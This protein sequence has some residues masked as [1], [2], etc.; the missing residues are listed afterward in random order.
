M[1]D[2]SN[3][4]VVPNFMGIKCSL[5]SVHSTSVSMLYQIHLVFP[6]CC[7][8]P[9]LGFLSWLLIS[10]LHPVHL[11]CYQLSTT[12]THP[13]SHPLFQRPGLCCALIQ[14]ENRQNNIRVTTS[15]NKTTTV[16]S[17]NW[18]DPVPKYRCDECRCEQTLSHIVVQSL[19]KS[20]WDYVAKAQ[21]RTIREM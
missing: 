18:C 20:L 6:A 4:V 5:V 9:C 2:C 13:S 21:N 7:D 16:S 12:P 1:P 17:Q 11:L 15:W 3:T 10:L 8:R 14:N 19:V